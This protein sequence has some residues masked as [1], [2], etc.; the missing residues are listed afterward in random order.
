M[1]P[2]PFLSRFGGLVVSRLPALAFTRPF[3][4]VAALALSTVRVFVVVVASL[5]A[6]AVEGA[7]LPCF[8]VVLYCIVLD[9][10]GLDWIRLD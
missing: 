2:H 7:V 5:F 6:V 8:A 1:R 9:W 3:G 10:V 4:A